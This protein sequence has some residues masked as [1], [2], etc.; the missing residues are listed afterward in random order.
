M[1]DNSNSKAYN[2]AMSTDSDEY[3]SLPSH[4]AEELDVIKY[5]LKKAE[6]A[7]K[8]AEANG[9]GEGEDR[10]GTAINGDDS[11]PESPDKRPNSPGDE[12]GLNKSA[13]HEDSSNLNRS[14]LNIYDK[15]MRVMDRFRVDDTVHPA[16]LY[17]RQADEI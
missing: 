14:K 3:K 2:D 10:A 17:E 15:F 13:S 6:D 1:R 9:S 4:T 8:A 16:K 11:E 7:K 5:N 12:E